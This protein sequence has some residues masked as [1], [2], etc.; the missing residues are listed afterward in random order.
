MLG[1]SLLFGARGV[2]ALFGPLVSGYWAGNERRR[3][4]VG[5]FGGFLAIA[6]GYLLLS[7]A[8]T[9]WQA[10]ATVI[11]AHAGGSTVWVF[12][13]TLLHF[14]TED[15]FRGRVFSADFGF[16]TLAMSVVTAIGGAAVDW[17]VSVRTVAFCT[18][19]LAIIP[20]GLWWRAQRLWAQP[21][22]VT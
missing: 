14:Q 16:L 21:A 10:I 6:A 5:I 11:L 18:G 15:R 2:G 17:G 3:L 22:K 19:A 9:V 20:A 12:S 4:R 8:S 1:M 13:T 7:G